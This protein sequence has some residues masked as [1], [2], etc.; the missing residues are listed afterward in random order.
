MKVIWP[1]PG[2]KR[3]ALSIT[4][5]SQAP[6]S[7]VYPNIW[8]IAA[9]SK[10]NNK[11][12]SWNCMSISPQLCISLWPPYSRALSTVQ[13]HN[14][15]TQPCITFNV[16]IYTYTQIHTHNGVPSMCPL[17]CSG[18]GMCGTGWHRHTG[19]LTA[20][21]G[22]GVGVIGP[23]HKETSS[24]QHCVLLLTPCSPLPSRNNGLVW[25]HSHKVFNELQFS[26]SGLQ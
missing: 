23:D 25:L 7:N 21:T 16:P 14:K 10:W 8:A 12:K 13:A 15:W 1:Q 2:L 18:A 3:S 9:R 4:L 26:F 24:L 22:W 11:K 19:Q 6:A 20:G 5:A 17:F